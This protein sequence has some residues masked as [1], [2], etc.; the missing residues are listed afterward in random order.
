MTTEFFK[1]R[2]LNMYNVSIY[3][4]VCTAVRFHMAYLSGTWWL[5]S[6]PVR[7]IPVRF[8]L[9]VRTRSY[10]TVKLAPKFHLSENF[11]ARRAWDNQHGT[12]MSLNWHEL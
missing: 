10:R 9:Y 11:S 5:V 6:V 1:F 2:H 12:Q 8:R 3:A 7:L 4:R